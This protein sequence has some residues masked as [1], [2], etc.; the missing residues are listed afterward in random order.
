MPPELRPAAPD[1]GSEDGIPFTWG[2]ALE[3]WDLIHADLDEHF[4]TNSHMREF[5]DTPWPITRD[6][7][8]A[9]LTSPTPTRFATAVAPAPDH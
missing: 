6:R 3:H 9:L 4:A 8:L 1:T 2:L 7:I 5:W